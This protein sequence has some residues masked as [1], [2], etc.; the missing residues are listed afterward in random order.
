MDLSTKMS[1]N[2]APH[3]VRCLDCGTEMIPEKIYKRKHCLCGN[4]NFIHFDMNWMYIHTRNIKRFEAMKKS[5]TS[6][7][8]EL[9]RRDTVSPGPPSSACILHK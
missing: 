6:G 2:I 9:D 1:L 5:S 7:H 4:A 3:G 8:K